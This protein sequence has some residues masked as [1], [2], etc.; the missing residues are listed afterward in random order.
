MVKKRMENKKK[1]SSKSVLSLSLSLQL[2]TS[3]LRFALEPLAINQTRP[4]CLRTKCVST[5][6]WNLANVYFVWLYPL[7]PIYVPAGPSMPSSFALLFACIMFIFI[8]NIHLHTSTYVY[9]RSRYMYYM[10]MFFLQ[11]KPVSSESSDHAMVS[12][13]IPFSF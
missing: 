11:M 13:L 5:F 10:G 8:S 3:S 2:T 7:I 4:H 1:K 9:L 12:S 6:D